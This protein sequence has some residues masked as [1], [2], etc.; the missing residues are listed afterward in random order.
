MTLNRIVLVILLGIIYIFVALKFD[1]LG[2][3]YNGF[4]VSAWVISFFLI[5][6]M[7]SKYGK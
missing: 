3:K 1:L 6:Y 2:S 4:A 5:S 7:L